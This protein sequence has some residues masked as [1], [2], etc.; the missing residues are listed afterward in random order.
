MKKADEFR[1]VLDVPI[2]KLSID[3]LVQEICLCPE[4]LKDIDCFV[5]GYM[6]L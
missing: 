4:Y 2:S 5:A 1:K 6:G 3:G